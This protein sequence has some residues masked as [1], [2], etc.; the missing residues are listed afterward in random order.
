MLSSFSVPFTLSLSLSLP[1]PLKEESVSIILFRDALSESL[2]CH[3]LPSIRIYC[4]PGTS[5]T[6]FKMILSL[7]RD[8][9]PLHKRASLFHLY[10]IFLSL[11]LFLYSLF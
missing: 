8:R 2:I 6:F 7:I 1:L 10:S 9:R 5:S 3:Q 4:Y 11:S